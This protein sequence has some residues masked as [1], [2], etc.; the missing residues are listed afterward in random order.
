MA[1]IHPRS[2]ERWQEWQTSRH[3]ARQ[4]KHAVAGALR[5]GDEPARPALALHSRAG[6]GEGRI[7][8]GVDSASPTSRASL[9]TAL[10]YLSA[11]V[12]VLAPAGVELPEIAGP[13][14]ERRLVEEPAP[15]LTGRGITT[16]LT[17]GW[18]LRV[19]RAVHEWALAQDVAAAVVQHGALTPY[20]PPLPPRTTLLAWS[21]ADAEFYRSGREDLEVRTVGSQLLWQAGREAD[22]PLVVEVDRPVFLGQMHGAELPRYV[23]AGT[24]YAFC[25]RE[26]ALYRPHPSELD[27]LSRAAHAVMRRRGIEFQDTS[28]PLGELR[29]P[30]VGVF[31]TGVLEA[32]VRGLPAYVEAR[33]APGWVHEFWDRYGLRRWGGEPTPAPTG[34]ADEPSRVI[35]QLLEGQA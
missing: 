16:A 30:V 28:L 11:P 26:G 13:E 7:L 6:S 8:L 2:L 31:S 35:A 17:L 19:G 23:T 4:V 33:R 25:R 3:R 18:H 27:A 1:L 15:A 22:G 21:D 14:W 32:A 9:L 5:R 12:D 34:P 24:A 29:R 10:P 20:A